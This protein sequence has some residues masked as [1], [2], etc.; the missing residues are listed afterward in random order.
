MHHAASTKSYFTSRLSVSITPC[1]HS[2]LLPLYPYALTQNLSPSHR[3]RK[4]KSLDAP[5]LEREFLADQVPHSTIDAVC[6][7][8]LGSR[9]LNG[10]LGEYLDR[11][12][13]L[14]VL[15]V[16]D[17]ESLKWFYNGEERS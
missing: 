16:V 5:R 15:G 9:A 6:V 10:L 3:G 8:V 4:G 14:F 13:G 7:T 11:W 17:G 1:Y 2:S 12:A